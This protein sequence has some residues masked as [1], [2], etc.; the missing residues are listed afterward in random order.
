MKNSKKILFIGGLLCMAS[1]AHASEDL[2]LSK[3]EKQ[4]LEL[5][6]SDPILSI[7]KSIGTLN[8]IAQ[9]IQNFIITLPNNED[10]N[11]KDCCQKILERINQFE[12]L[13]G[14]VLQ[15]ILMYL[16][17]GN[18]QAHE[19]C[20]KMEKHFEEVDMLLKQTLNQVLGLRYAMGS[21]SDLSVGEQDFNSVQDIDDAQLSAISWLKTIYRE[22][23]SGKFNS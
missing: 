8:E 20:H 4:E 9:Q 23:L 10:Q 5:I 11:I 2:R 12:D 13:M 22:Q 21:L 16:E 3:K 17:K 1:L 19:C 15:G 6:N 7:K 18:T 14:Q